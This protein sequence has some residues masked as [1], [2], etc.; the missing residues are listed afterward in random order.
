MD[1]AKVARVASLKVLESVWAVITF[2][3]FLPYFFLSNP[4]RPFLQE[5]MS[6]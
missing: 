4:S 5:G 6:K 2:G 1:E 3:I